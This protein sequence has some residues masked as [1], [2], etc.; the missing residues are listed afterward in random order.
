MAIEI[1]H[2]EVLNN[3][4][5]F[6]DRLLEAN[7]L[8]K[9]REKSRVY[10]VLLNRKTGNMRFA[11]RISNLEHHFSTKSKSVSEDWKEVRLIVG[12]KTSHELH[13]EVRGRH[14]EILHMHDLTPLAWRV[15][16]ETLQVLHTKAMQTKTDPSAH[17][18]EETLLQDLSSI[19]L[20]HQ[21]EEIKHHPA[22]EGHIDFLHAEKKL[23]AQPVGAYVI[24]A[25]DDLTAAIVQQLSESNQMPISA[26]LVTFVREAGK[27]SDLL[28]LHT[29]MGW[30]LYRDEPCL[31]Q[32][33]TYSSL[34]SLLDSGK[35]FTV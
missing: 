4:I 22:W 20:S 6:K 13:F 23:R 5:R 3:L 31:N 2:R 35:L 11:Q 12:G 21:T 25:C 34:Q 19:H 16:E 8:E 26:Y 32:C 29:R 9:D 7:G 27:I 18:P 24:R 17:L 30:I 10:T 33:R 1:T 28:L 14:N 15:A